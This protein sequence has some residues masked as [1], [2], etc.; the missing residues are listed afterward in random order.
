MSL[1]PWL[2]TFIQIVCIVIFASS[3]NKGGQSA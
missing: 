2:L 1:V 3:D